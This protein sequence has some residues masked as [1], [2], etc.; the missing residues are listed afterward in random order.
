MSGLAGLGGSAEEGVGDPQ[1]RFQI[2]AI[3]YAFRSKRSGE[4]PK[5][6]A[7]AGAGQRDSSFD[8]E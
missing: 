7:A 5:A 1:G 6:K 4:Q 8:E 3:K 2:E